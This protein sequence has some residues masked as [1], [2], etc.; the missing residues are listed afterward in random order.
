M[1]RVKIPTILLNFAKSFTKKAL[2]ES[3]KTTNAIIGKNKLQ[4]STNTI[5]GKAKTEKPQKG[6]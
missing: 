2:S 6:A 3:T 1:I 4:I 5:N